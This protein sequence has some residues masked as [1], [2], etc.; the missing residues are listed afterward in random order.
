MK[1]KNATVIEMAKIISREAVREI[2]PDMIEP[3]VRPVPSR[4]SL[5]QQN[6]RSNSQR[7]RR[8]RRPR[9]HLE[10]IEEVDEQVREPNQASVRN[11]DS[12]IFIPGLQRDM[13]SGTLM[14][15]KK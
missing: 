10:I 14:V 13:R 9:N 11:E 15:T 2:D 5:R 3:E 4:L 1:R 8:M 12:S 6:S 7:I